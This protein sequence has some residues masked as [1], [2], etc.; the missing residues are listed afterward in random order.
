MAALLATGIPLITLDDRG[1]GRR[2]ADTIVNVLVEEPEP[3]SLRRETRLLEGGDYV[4]LDP[5]FAIVQERIPPRVF[6]PLRKVFVAMGGADAAGLSV[7]V[8]RALK[9]VEGLEEVQFV[10][11]PAFPRLADLQRTVQDTPWRCQLLASLPGLLD[12]YLWSDLAIVAGGLTMY[13][14]CCV[15]TPALAV[16]QPIDHQL[17]LADR[18]SFAGAMA[19][20]GYGLDAS[21]ERIAEQV[22]RLADPDIRREMSLRGPTLVDGNGTARVAEALI[23]TA[24]GGGRLAG[25]TSR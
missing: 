3:E 18:L 5:V 16:C 7:K 6:G 23:E 20:V 11:G 8:A 17:E 21:E 19:T 12:R 14:V 9:Q 13:E 15:G 4:V 22:C 1:P 2:F 10:C 25:T 24:G